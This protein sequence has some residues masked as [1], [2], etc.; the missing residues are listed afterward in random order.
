MT[1]GAGGETV[2]LDHA[3]CNSG[4]DS[5]GSSSR[6]FYMSDSSEYPSQSSTPDTSYSRA[7]DY[8]PPQR[9][10]V[11]DTSSRKDSGLESGEN[12]DEEISSVKCN[13]KVSKAKESAKQ[14]KIAAVSLLLK[15]VKVEKE[16]S[17]I[18]D[19]SECLSPATS[20]GQ[21]D[22]EVEKKKKKKL[23][24]EE[25]RVRREE[26]ERILSQESSRANSPVSNAA[27]ADSTTTS[28][29]SGEGN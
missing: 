14:N 12:S 9:R 17:A 4:G 23:N 29:T 5:A 22:T 25:Y 24:L 19:V 15:N 16:V 20:V 7:S 8:F 28:I 2:Q 21:D 27:P 1:G 18:S 6:S 13:V 10:Q 26:Q 11:Q 3:Y